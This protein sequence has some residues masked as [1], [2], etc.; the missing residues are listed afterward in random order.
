MEEFGQLGVDAPV[1]EE[2]VSAPSIVQEDKQL[3]SAVEQIQQE[4]ATQEGSGQSRTMNVETQE[5]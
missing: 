1:T 4:A 3:E 2:S 5:M